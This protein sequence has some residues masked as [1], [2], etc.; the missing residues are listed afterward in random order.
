MYSFKRKPVKSK[1]GCIRARRIQIYFHVL[2]YDIDHAPL[3]SSKDMSFNEAER[4]YIKLSKLL[5][6]VRLRLVQIQTPGHAGGMYVSG[7]TR[8]LKDEFIE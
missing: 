5:S 7:H 1:F 8:K 3:F 2:A 4:F 6:G